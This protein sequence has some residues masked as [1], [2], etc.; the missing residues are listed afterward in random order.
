[1]STLLAV[2]GA[3]H[4]ETH[5]W[6]GRLAAG[7][8]TM[9]IEGSDIDALAAAEGLT[10]TSSVDDSDTAWKLFGG[11]R[12][13]TNLGLEAGYAG[14]G[15]ISTRSTVTAPA[16]GSFDIDLDVTAWNIDAVGI[17]PIG[18]G[19]ELFGKL[20]VSMWETDASVSGVAAGTAFSGTAGDDGNDVHFGLGASYRLTEAIGI[21]AEWERIDNDDQDLDAWTFGAQFN[22]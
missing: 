11:Y 9:D 17:V 1:M 16:A 8:S 7:R 4:A 13:T 22:F 12:L 20:G 3:A 14:Y 10:T 2:S 18:G 6:Y 5:G 15:T 19:F 21:R